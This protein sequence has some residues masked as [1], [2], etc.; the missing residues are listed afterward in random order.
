ML[1]L[2]DQHLLKAHPVH[3]EH[4]LSPS[5]ALQGALFGDSAAGERP[6]LLHRSSDFL[7]DELVNIAVNLMRDYKES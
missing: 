3:T 5:P 7:E 1:D 6:L 4:P 2:Q